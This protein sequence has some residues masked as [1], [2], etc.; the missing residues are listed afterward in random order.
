MTG[1]LNSSCVTGHTR[2]GG[3][4]NNASKAVF[5]ADARDKVGGESGRRVPE[6]EAHR[7]LLRTAD[8]LA[9]VFGLPIGDRSDC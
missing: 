1:S 3:L 7:P 4:S 9:V 8:I 5:A 2:S 6:G